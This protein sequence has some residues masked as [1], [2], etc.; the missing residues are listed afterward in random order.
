MRVFTITLIALCWCLQTSNSIATVAVA[1]CT[2]CAKRTQPVGLL[3][4]LREAREERFRREAQVAAAAARAANP[5]K[6]QR[7]TACRAKPKPCSII[8]RY[9]TIGGQIEQAMDF[10]PIRP[11]LTG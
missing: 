4:G 11:T 6:P 5:C 9:A 1:S 2:A 10:V 8:Q 3:G 7:A